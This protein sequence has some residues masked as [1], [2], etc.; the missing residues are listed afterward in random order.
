VT[1]AA[2]QL[3]FGNHPIPHLEESPIPNNAAAPFE[4]KQRVSTYGWPHSS[5]TGEVAAMGCCRNIA[6]ALIDR[7]V[8]AIA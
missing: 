8:S 2:G 1:E 5:E 6:I 3:D 7:I 4:S